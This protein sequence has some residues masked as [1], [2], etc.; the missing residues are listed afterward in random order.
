ME[1]ANLPI[2]LKFEN[3]KKSDICVIFE[4]NVGGH[5]TGGGLKWSKGQGELCPRPGPKTATGC[6]P[7][8]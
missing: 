8:L 5:E 1:A 7:F 2:F 3:A 6:G 4:K